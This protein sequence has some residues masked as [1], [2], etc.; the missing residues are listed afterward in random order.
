M[1]YSRED[2]EGRYLQI[3][4]VG[5]AVDWKGHSFEDF[6]LRPFMEKV[7]PTLR[8]VAP[9]PTAM[10]YGTGTGPGACF[11]AARG[12]RVDAIDLSPT[13]IQLAR[14]FAA[15]R[16]LDVRFEVAD[17][18]NFPDLGRCYD[19]VVDSFCL[20]RIVGD[21]ERAKAL[22]TVRSL[23][24]PDGYFLVATV[25]FRE[26]RDFGRDLFDPQTGTR[27]RRVGE[28][29]QNFEEVVHMEQGWYVP[30]RRYLRAHE[31]YSELEASGFQILHQEGGRVVCV[32]HERRRDGS[33]G[34]SL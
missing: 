23:L 30:F 6:D 8:I 15:E 27:Y 24:K 16:G 25:L 22:E 20:Q 5:R 7:L 34:A 29:K 3:A 28:H 14:R 17:I 18:C 1:K 11:L 33:A 31:L 10:E 13:A 21:A 26:G 12:F 2:A 4:S 19:L 9:E 32:G